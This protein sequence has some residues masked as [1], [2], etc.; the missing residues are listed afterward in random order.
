MHLALGPVA[1]AKGLRSFYET[2]LYR[3][4]SDYRVPDLS[5]V[6]PSQVVKRGIEGGAELV[7][8]I[9]SP[10]DE[11][12]EKLPWYAAFLVK[13]VLIIDPETRA[14]EFFVL[15]GGQLHAVV[16]DEKGQFRSA[17]LGVTFATR[18]GPKLEISGPLGTTLI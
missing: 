8:E 4:D 18:E 10:D 3:K 17:V 9:L 15:R 7:I 12:H 11:S 1:K 16:A 5:F 6:L 2:A 13:E 14:L